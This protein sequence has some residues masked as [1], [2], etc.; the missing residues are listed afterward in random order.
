MGLKEEKDF[1]PGIQAL[2]AIEGFEHRLQAGQNPAT[3]VKLPARKS[4]G[5]AA[6]LPKGD[7]SASLKPLLRLPSWRRPTNES[8]RPKTGSRL[9]LWQV[10]AA[11]PHHGPAPA[12]ACPSAKV[13]GRWR[14]QRPRASRARAADPHVRWRRITS[15]VSTLSDFPTASYRCGH[16]WGGMPAGW[17]TR[18]TFMSYELCMHTLCPI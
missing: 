10:V 16:R 7:Q 11:F 5:S 13:S 15:F 12:R 2:P 8:P 9:L 18:F 14:A 17:P 4:C 3:P 6:S 1:P